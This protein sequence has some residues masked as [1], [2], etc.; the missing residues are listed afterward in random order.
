MDGEPVGKAMWQRKMNLTQHF[1][2]PIDNP[3]DNEIEKAVKNL[4]KDMIQYTPDDRPAITQVVNRLS[5]LKAQ[6]VKICDYEIIVNENHELWK[7]SSGTSCSGVVYSGQHVV[8]KKQVAAKRYVTETENE[9][10]VAYFENERNMMENIIEPHENIVQSYHSSK[11]EYEEDGKQM[12]EYWLI[13]ELCNLGALDEYATD[14]ELTIKQKLR[15][16]IQA[17]R[18][19]H[20]LHEQ[21]PAG[22]V[23]KYINPWKLLVSGK[24]E[25]PIIKLCNFKFATTTDRDHV[26]FSMESRVSFFSFL[27]PEQTQR[28][29]DEWFTRLVYDRTV[30]IYALGISCL[31]LL[32]AVMGSYI[33]RP[34][35]K[36]NKAHV[37]YSLCILTIRVK[38]N[39]LQDEI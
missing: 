23:H 29:D 22:V 7:R 19:V 20:H 10:Y 11:K 13:M 6:V 26:P 1:E 30:D 12:V 35:G 3:T 8:T 39:Y 2:P 9:C 32:E 4:M 16:I 24:P 27:A 21:K 28:D 25:T 31:M 36:F 5:A 17:S 37:I 15:L 33:E 38:Q 14:R 34:Q 18:A